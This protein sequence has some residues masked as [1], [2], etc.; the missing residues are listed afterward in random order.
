[1]TKIK[2]A[3]LV[4]AL[5]ILTMVFP[6][7][8]AFAHDPG[9]NEA[10]VEVTVTEPVAQGDVA[11][12]DSQCNEDSG[13]PLSEDT[14]SYDTEPVDDEPNQEISEESNKLSSIIDV[15][16]SALTVTVNE[17]SVNLPT[18][19]EKVEDPGHSTVIPTEN[20][21]HNNVTNP[22]SS[23][24]TNTNSPAFTKTNSSAST[25][26]EATFCNVSSAAVESNTQQTDSNKTDTE[27]QDQGLTP[28]G[29]LTLV[30]DY[31]EKR[32]E[33][34]Q[35]IT[36]VTKSGNYFYLIIDRN[37]KGEETV[38]FL[39]LVD[40]SD[41]LALMEE[42]EATKYQSQLAAE[43]AAKEAAEQA[44]AEAAAAQEKEDE[45][46][47]TD[48]ESDKKRSSLLPILTIVILITAGACGWFYMQAKKKKKAD[49]TPDPDAD[50]SDYD[51]EDYGAG[52]YAEVIEPSY[53]TEINDEGSAS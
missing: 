51:E 29:N 27:G 17:C 33:G 22:A 13:E 46:D 41:L 2:R 47:K 20:G 19:K 15:L 43:Q 21:N 30:D 45:P 7:S 31:G 1:M 10:P 3:F 18:E 36:L 24:P 32:G 42:D 26:K 50:Y 35:F 12:N 5:L 6:V 48:R 38:H 23:N 16:I 40:E 34:Q 49:I 37:E 14:G 11:E 25:Q 53:E 28:K 52:Q 44:A 39:N 8:I 4:A 9:T